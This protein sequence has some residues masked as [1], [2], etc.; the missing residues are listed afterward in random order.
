MINVAQRQV[1]TPNPTKYSRYW[2]KLC[3]STN[4]RFCYFILISLY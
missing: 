3:W 1:F 4:N 2:N